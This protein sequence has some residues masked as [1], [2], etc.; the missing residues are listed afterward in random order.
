MAHRSTHPAGRTLHVIDIEN[1][2]GG[3]GAGPTAVGPALSAYRSAVAVGVDDHAVIGSGPTLAIA[4]GLA[5]PGAQLRFGHGVDGADR[6]LLAAVEPAFAADH[7]DRVVVASGDHAFVP[8]VAALR[9]RG[10]AVLVVTRDHRSASVDLCRLAMHRT[11]PAA[12]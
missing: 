5:W 3:S 9:A 2:V 6:A 1:L 4:A 11:L 8:L 10:V 12:S 7:Y